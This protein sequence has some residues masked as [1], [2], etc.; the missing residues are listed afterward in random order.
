M[1]GRTAP[2][3]VL[4]AICLLVGACAPAVAPSSA[5]PTASPTA[6]GPTPPP[7]FVRPTPLPSPTFFVYVV[8]SGDSLS[9]IA[10]SFST[11]PFSIA[12]WNRDSYQSL[13]PESEGYD[14]NR[15]VVG[16]M[17]RLIP[18]AEVDEE[19]LLESTP[20]AS[21]TGAAAW[22]TGGPSRN[23]VVTRADGGSIVLMHLGGFNTLDALPGIVAGLCAPR[24]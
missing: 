3:A 12:V 10:R 4:I 21:P 2:L 16:W 5:E 20:A 7:S 8:R 1:T 19:D 23:K 9:S 6:S 24:A 17:L 13:D 11:T 18:G 15:V 14:P 22:S